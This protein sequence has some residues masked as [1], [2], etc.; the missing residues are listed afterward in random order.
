MN[1]GRR[2]TFV[3]QFIPQFENVTTTLKIRWF[4]NSMEIVFNNSLPGVFFSVSADEESLESNLTLDIDDPAILHDGIIKCYP[5]GNE[6]TG[7][8]FAVFR[9][10][11]A[12]RTGWFYCQHVRM[13]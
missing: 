11:L 6:T 9:T 4:F 3:C 7:D 13:F 5:P 8:V 12:P 2:E 1:S 10:F